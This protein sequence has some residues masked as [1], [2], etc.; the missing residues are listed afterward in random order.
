M[1]RATIAALLVSGLFAAPAFAADN[2]FYV[3]AGVGQGYVKVD[4]ARGSIISTAMTRAS[5]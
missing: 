5:R 2:G 3:G 4:D 1:S